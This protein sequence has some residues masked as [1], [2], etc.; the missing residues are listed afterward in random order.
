[1]KRILQLDGVRALAFLI[2]FFHHAFDLPLMWAGVDV[3]FVL[4]GFLITGILMEA[5][6]KEG[7]WSHF[8]ERRALRILP[9][10]TLLLI[11]GTYV[12]RIHWGWDILWYVFFAQNFAYVLHAGPTGLGILWSLAVEEQFYLFWPIV[13]LNYGPRTVKRVAIGL[14]CLAPVLRGVATPFLQT[15][16]PIYYLM[17]FRMDLLASGAI[18]A[19]LWRERADLAKWRR[20]GLVMMGGG[21]VL[22]ALCSRFVHGFRAMSNIVS[23][24]MLG[25]SLI[26]CVA[27]GL[28]AFSLG[29]ERGWWMAFTTA[30]PVRW[31][32]MVSYSGYL[33]HPFCIGL[34]T[35]FGSRAKDV[36]LALVVALAYASLSWVLIEKPIMKLRPARWIRERRGAAVQLS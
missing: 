3:F 1:M 36:P 17:P 5:R 29:T 20:T 30:R 2:I 28:I 6:G 13:A 31:I 24:N 7:A 32:G 35:P 25:Y 18:L 8:Y 21:A 22:F 33:I 4:S 14:V 19:V 26:C 16:W 11:I 9:P 15:H 27:T 23:Y 12:I 10:L 34:V